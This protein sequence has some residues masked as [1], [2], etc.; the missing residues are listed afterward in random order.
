MDVCWLSKGGLCHVQKCNTVPDEGRVE[1][2]CLSLTALYQHQPNA[3]FHLHHIVTSFPAKY[4]PVISSLK[5]TYLHEIR[6]AIHKQPKMVGVRDES[7]QS[8]TSS[9]ISSATDDSDYEIVPR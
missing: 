2:G 8:D 3:L 5:E 6:N 1:D 4:L 9:I 7:D